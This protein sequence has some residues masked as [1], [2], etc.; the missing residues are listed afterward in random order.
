MILSRFFPVVL[1]ALSETSFAWTNWVGVL[2]DWPVPADTKITAI[3]SQ[4][5]ANQNTVTDDKKIT[6]EYEARVRP[7]FVRIDKKSWQA[8]PRLQDKNAVLPLPK[9]LSWDVCFSGR[10]DGQLTAML[11][12]DEQSAITPPYM[13]RAEDRAPWR[14]RRS[15]DYAGWLETPV[16]KPILLKSSLNSSCADPQKWRQAGVE[17][18]RSHLKNMIA[19]LRKKMASPEDVKDFYDFKDA[20]VKI[21]R[22]WASTTSGLVV[23][24]QTLPK[25]RRTETFHILKNGDIHHLGTDMLLIDAGDFDGDGQAEMLFK[26]HTDKKDIYDLYSDTKHLAE[27][28]WD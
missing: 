19:A 16:Y 7:L 14:T 12:T 1:L 10:S 27:S 18:S 15:S 4:D 26:R 23:S 9:A 2:E 21:K 5:T 3:S 28:V 13:L 8:A 25:T 20:D 6:Q 11:R 17:K 24:I 22:T